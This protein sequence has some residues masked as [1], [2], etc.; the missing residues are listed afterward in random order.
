MMRH[1]AASAPPPKFPMGHSLLFLLT[2]GEKKGGP[3]RLGHGGKKLW[4]SFTAGGI[5]DHIGGG[6]CRYSTDRAFHIP[7]L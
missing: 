5:Y 4:S 1:T 3:R 2:Y 6:F 7:P